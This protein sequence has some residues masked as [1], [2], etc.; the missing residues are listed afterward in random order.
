M[1]TAF[2]P[3][4]RITD[5]LSKKFN[6]LKG[7]EVA[8]NNVNEALNQLVEDYASKPVRSDEEK[9]LLTDRINK[10]L[11][12]IFDKGDVDKIIESFSNDPIFDLRITQRT[13]NR[14]NEVAH[15]L[16]DTTA[17]DQDAIDYFMAG[18]VEIRNKVNGVFSDNFQAFRFL[19]LERHEGQAVNTKSHR[20]LSEMHAS[21]LTIKLV[22]MVINSGSLREHAK[23]AHEKKQEFGSSFWPLPQ[24]FKFYH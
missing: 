5:R 6:S 13:F 18:F 20:S 8:L 2:T 4:G 3:A 15:S 9:K 21:R 22:E 10:I 7:F 19:G 23:S 11:Q 17:T 14:L 12:M 1:K 16:I 24:G